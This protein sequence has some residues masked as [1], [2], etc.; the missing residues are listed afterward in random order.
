[1]NKDMTNKAK[2]LIVDDEVNIRLTLSKILTKK[3]YTV[4]TAENGLSAFESVK[5]E[6]FDV[7]LMDVK[8]PIMNGLEALIHI[9]QIRPAAN[10]IFMSAF[11]IEDIIKDIL[12]GH[13]YTMIK[14]PLNVDEVINVIEAIKKEKQ[15]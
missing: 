13:S 6:D 11:S 14:K 12:K 15:L 3:G 2:V 4:S 5:K 8:M 9:R 1:M 7:I 10:I